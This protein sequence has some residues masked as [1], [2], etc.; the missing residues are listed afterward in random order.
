SARPLLERGPH[1][2]QRA[3][4]RL[5][6]ILRI[7]GAVLSQNGGR[8]VQRGGGEQH[9]AVED[10]DRRWRDEAEPGDLKR[11]AEQGSQRGENQD[12]ASGCQVMTALV[13]CSGTIWCA[14]VSVMPMR[15]GRRIAQTPA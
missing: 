10:E 12:R 6:V 7:H 2:R 4:E 15:S 1:A 9:G 14:S 13:L 5:V 8:R 11:R 3:I